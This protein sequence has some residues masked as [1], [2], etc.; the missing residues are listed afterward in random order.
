MDDE[1]LHS[2]NE[3]QRQA[4][5]HFEGPALV[6]AGAGSGKTRTVVHRVAYLIAQRGVFPSE[7]LAVTFTNKAAEEMRERLRRMVRGAGELWVSTFHAAALRLLRV[8]GERV[9]LKPGFVVYDEDDQTALLKEVLK[10]LGLAARPGPIKALL[11]RAKNR[12]EAPET[13]L[14][15]LPEYYGGLSRGRLLEVVRRYGEALRAQG[16]LDF[17]DILLY[18]LRLLEGDGEVLRRVRRRARFIHVDEYQDTSPVQYRLTKLLAGEEANLM[19][20]GDPDQGIYSFRAAD[21]KNILEFT[22]DFPGAKVY[23][24]EE[25]YRSTEAILRFANAVIARNA[26]RLEKTLRAVRPGGEPVRLYRAR[27][28]R[29]EARFVAEEIQRLGPPFDRVAV[30]Y[31]TNAQSRLLEQALASRGIGARVVGGVGF[32][33]RAEVKDLLAYA[34]L[35]LNPLDGVSLKRVLNTPPRGIGPATVEKLTRIAQERGLPLY[36]ALRVGAEAL[37][38]PEPLRHFLALM[39]ELGDLAFGPAEGFFRHLLEATDY[40]AYLKEAYPEDLEDR[41]ENVE[42]LL[43]AAREAEGLVEFLDKVALTARAEE[44]AEAGG[45]VALMTLHNA[46]GLEFPV[47]FLVGVEEGLLPHRSSASTL[48]GLE[49][50]RRLFYVGLTRAQERLY[51][52]H[53]EEREV[54]GRSESA[55]PSRF[56]EEVEEGLYQEYDPYRERPPRPAPPTHKPKPGAYRGGEKVVHPRFG[57]GTVVAASG[58]EVTV[59]FE[60]VGLKRLSLRYADLRPA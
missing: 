27:D 45:R 50:E 57:P 31:R 15:D 21:I 28:A 24:L 54:Y 49:E 42:E 5:L 53:A 7:I 44:P 22:R 16:A 46:K 25:N 13:L 43:R 52:S 36:E 58:D 56:L 39:E 4:V 2:L 38:R 18:A 23:R 9:G 26:L 11:D 19:A 30:L 17:G 35:A 20:V 32:F 41:L 48:E 59:H 3:A 60:G 51:L 29:D 33:E 55:R 10:E 6:V 47:V 12:G 40:P 14:Q 37:P 8:Y 34:R 1:L